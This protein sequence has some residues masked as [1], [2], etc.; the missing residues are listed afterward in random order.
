MQINKNR[1]KPSWEFF[2]LELWFFKF[3]ERRK[4]K[5][6]GLG[7]LFLVVAAIGV[8]PLGLQELGAVTSNPQ[9]VQDARDDFREC[10]STC[11]ETFQVT[12]DLCRDVSHDCAEGCRQQFTDCIGP[13]LADLET[14]KED[15]DS[16]RDQA[17]AECR[18]QYSGNPSA[19]DDCIDTAQVQAFMCR[20]QCREQ[21]QIRAQ[22]RQCRQQF[23][24]CI[25]ACPP[26]N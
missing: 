20:D 14:C 21:T 26:Q 23:R 11:R 7:V 18:T 8:G 13:S 24:S 9:C 6:K 10:L 12:K 4:C 5:M 2:R 1:C 15:C 3:E 17:V 16:D 19:L 25:G 22:L